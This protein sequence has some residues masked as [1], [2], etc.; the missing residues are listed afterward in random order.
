MDKFLLAGLGNPGEKYKETRH[1]IGFEIIDALCSNF[2]TSF[3]LAKHGYVASIKIKGRQ[4][5]L[6]KPTTFM[7]L[8]GRA[9]KYYLF[10]NKIKLEN[11]LV[12]SDDLHL[13]FGKIKIKRKGS[14]GGH[15]GH[16][17]IIKELETQYYA[18]LKFGVSNKF[19]SGN[20]SKY[21]LSPFQSEERSIIND[22]I[23]V[24]VDAMINFCTLG[25]EKTMAEFN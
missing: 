18:R 25:I 2:E 3:E 14:D 12:V 22:F 16:K 19:I 17:D 24:S 20:Q 21:V 7:N 11:L 1:N 10:K 8:S 5:F 15:N 23:N 6:L 13:P 4:V 9:V